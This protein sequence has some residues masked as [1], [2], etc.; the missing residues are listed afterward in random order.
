MRHIKID[1]GNENI[2]FTEDNVRVGNIPHGIVKLTDTQIQK[3][4]DD[5]GGVEHLPP[6]DFIRLYKNLNS[7][8]Y[9]VYHVG[10]N[11][12]IDHGVL[13]ARQQRGA[14]RYTTD[15]ALPLILRVLSQY[16][17]D[18]G[19]Y[20][21][22]LMF[23]P[24]NAM[25]MKEYIQA[26]KRSWKIGDGTGVRY[27]N[28]VNVEVFMEGLGSIVHA[29]QGNLAPIKRGQKY[30]AIDIGSFTTDLVMAEQ[31]GVFV[32][33]MA[34]SLENYGVNS[35]KENL[36]LAIRRRFRDDFKDA[37][38]LE[39]NEYLESILT[40]KTINIRGR[41]IEKVDDIVNDV[42][43]DL[44]NAVL[45]GIDRK[46]SRHVARIGAVLLTGGGSS[47]MHTVLTERIDFS[48][49]RLAGERRIL[50]KVNV[51]GAHYYYEALIKAGKIAV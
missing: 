16:P 47:L 14:G 46:F 1:L 12:L 51:R 34:D 44:I 3:Y 24:S 40:T 7:K 17:D 27:I 23:P 21:L 32:P 9:S 26:I 11:A 45:T 39:D 18:D 48:Q 41:R 25:Y 15:Y 19:Q 43:S 6:K 33:G 50:Y 42:C 22:T 29:I 31:N 49:V 28:I 36:Q 13:K 37:S 8:E 5:C 10:N 35:V 20:S 38:A 30:L 4:A 2:K